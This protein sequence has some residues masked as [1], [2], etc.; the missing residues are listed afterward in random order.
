M[1]ET[2]SGIYVIENLINGKKYVGQGKDV[3]KRMNEDHHGSAPLQSAIEKYGK[4]NFTRYVVE[5]CDYDKELLT[6]REIYYIDILHSH[7]SEWGYNIMR[8]DDVTGGMTHTEESIQKIIENKPDVRGSNNPNYGNR[9]EKNPLYGTHRPEETREE[10]SFEISKHYQ[11]IGYA[12][13]LDKFEETWYYYNKQG[14][15]KEDAMFNEYNEYLQILKDKSPKTQLVY[16]TYLELL[17]KHFNIAIIDDINKLKAKDFVDFRDFVNGN[18]TTKNLAIQVIKIFM[19][20]LAERKYITNIEEIR[21][22]KRLKQPKRVGKFLTDEFKKKLIDAAK[23]AD[24]RAIL[25]LMIYGGLRRDEIVKLKKSDYVDGH[26]TINGKGNRQRRI[27][28]FPLAKEYLDKY[29]AGRKDDSEYLFVAHRSIGGV[30]HGL[31]G[32][33]IWNQ[34]RATC[35]RAGIDPKMVWPHLLRHTFASGLINSGTN[36]ILVRDLMGHSSIATTELYSHSQSSVLDD[37]IDSQ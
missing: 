13:P 17:F 34:V 5:Y 3:H 19:N 24:V 36:M 18:A 28:V 14:Q 16:R 35:I 10:I 7:I 15:R 31:T 25:T 6:K 20:F 32:Q 1:K 21:I 26:I 37:V 27:K 22:I 23:Y 30:Y 9:G 2:K 29:L 8:G 4:E 11:E 33:S 12:N